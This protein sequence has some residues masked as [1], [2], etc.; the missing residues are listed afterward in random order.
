MKENTMQHKFLPI[1]LEKGEDGFYVVECP[2]LPGC[3]TQG[4]TVEE[5]IKNIRE[6]IDL[7][8]EDQENRDILAAYNPEEFSLHAIAV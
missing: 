1:L 2:A 3:F 5:A 7:L 8:L 6:V 4:E